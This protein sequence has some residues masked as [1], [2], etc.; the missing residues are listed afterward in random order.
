MDEGEGI[1]GPRPV[2]LS[3]GLER[4]ALS[5]GLEKTLRRGGLGNPDVVLIRTREGLVVVKDFAPRPYWVRQ[6]LGRWLTRH[7]QRV[8]QALEGVDLVP[9]LLGP[10]DQYAFALE[11]RPGRLLSRALKRELPPDFL[12]ELE[13]GVSEMHQRGIVHLDLSHR[14]NILLGEDGRPVLLDF[15]S[16]IRFGAGHA[17]GRALTRGLAQIDRRALRKWRL[18]L[19]SGSSD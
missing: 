1:P 18:K 4:A 12:S 19:G 5:R 3:S 16:A 7:E 6:T 11:Y 9:R 17:L 10:V 2:S 14:S 15:A 8:Y 13:R